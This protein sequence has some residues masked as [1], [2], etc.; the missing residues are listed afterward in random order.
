MLRSAGSSVFQI[1]A[2]IG[3]LGVPLVAARTAGWAAIGLVGLCWMSF[4][5]QLLLAPHAYL[6]GS[7]LGGIA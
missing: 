1:C 4:R 7:V 6:L 3:A 5:V 2:V